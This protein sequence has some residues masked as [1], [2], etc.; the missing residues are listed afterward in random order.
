MLAGTDAVS[1]DIA[2]FD[3]L[4]EVEPKLKGKRFDNIPHLRNAADLGVGEPQY[5]IIECQ[6]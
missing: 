3:L 1:L 4:K 6:A 5:K 2:G